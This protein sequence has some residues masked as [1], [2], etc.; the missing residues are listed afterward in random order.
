MERISR[1]D[2]LRNAALFGA[3]GAVASLPGVAEAAAEVPVQESVT[4][5]VPGLDPAHDGLKVAQLSDIHLGPRTP[6]ALVRAALGDV[7]TWE[8]DLVVLTG[9][10]VSRQKRE[11]DDIRNHLGGL[12]APTV[13]VL[14]NHDVWVDPEGTAAA[15]RGL[16]YEVLENQWTTL[17]LRGEP[18]HLVGVG[19]QMTGREDVARAVR[20]LPEGPTP[21]VLAHGPRTADHLAP[22]SRP[23]VCLSG[24]THGGQINIPFLT[25]IIL[26]GFGR[27]PYLRG[28][29][30][31]GRVSLYVNRGIGMSGIKVR[32]NAAPEVTLA[33]LRRAEPDG[34][35][36]DGAHS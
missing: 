16:G 13:A 10:F 17:R 7:A 11:V 19:D 18:L 25:P 28:R 30:Q 36:P 15:L 27:E 29:H 32:V 8:P 5:W 22:L 34:S 24:H 33:T 12:A 6:E 35:H 2:F 31:V 21:L 20:G 3:A 23:M 9:D 4:F 26:S 14:G 1:R